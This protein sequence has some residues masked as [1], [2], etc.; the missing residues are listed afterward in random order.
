MEKTDKGAVETVGPRGLR[1]RK[2]RAVLAGGL[3]LGVGAAVT[4]AAWNDSEFARGT[5]G[6]GHFNLQGSTD[7]TTF[8]DHASGSPASLSFS[9]GFNTLSPDD[10]VSAPFVLHL[11]TTTTNDAVVSVASATGSGTAA[12]QLSYRILQVASVAACTPTATG[13]VIVPAGTA[14]NS[15]TGATTFT[16]T[17]SAAGVVPGADAFLCVLVT[18]SPTIVQDTAAVGTWEFRGT[19]TP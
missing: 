13:T 4:L 11:D 15:V 1:S 12:L 3:V 16:L 9:L 19:S 5:F 10:T 14:L 17:K 7:G 6:A 8:G 18:A 2:V